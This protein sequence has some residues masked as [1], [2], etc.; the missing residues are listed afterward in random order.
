MLTQAEEQWVRQK[1][2]EEELSNLR[3]QVAEMECD[4]YTE[5]V[6]NYTRICE[7]VNQWTKED[8]ILYLKAPYSL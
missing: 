4:L 7:I 1:M 8:L 5:E 2:E 6:C 3:H